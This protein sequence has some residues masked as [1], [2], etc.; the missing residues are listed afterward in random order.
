M[1]PRPRSCAL[2]LT[3]LGRQLLAGDT[4]APEPVASGTAL[5]VQPNFEVL[6][7]DALANLDLLSSLDAF[8]ESHSLDRAAIYRLTRPALVRGLEAG[9][10]EERVVGLLE[11]RSGAPL[12]Q[13]VRQTLHDWAREYERIHLYRDATLLEAPDAATLDGWLA[14]PKLASLLDRRLTA[15]TALLRPSGATAAATGLER[16]GVAVTVF[17]YALDAPQTLD[18]VGPDRVI[19]APEDDDP[20]LRYRLD[21]FADRDDGAAVGDTGPGGAAIPG[22]I[23]YRIGRESLARARVG[24]Q[25][26]DEILSFLGYK[27]RV[28]LSPDD[29]LTLR[30]WSGYYA[31]FRWAKVRA[32]ELPPTVSWGDLSRVKA[33]RPLILRVLS[34]SLALVSEEHWPE[35]EAALLA[36]GIGLKG[37][38]LAQ[39]AAERESAARRVAD[40]LGLA[41][42]RDLLERGAAPAPPAGR[43]RTMAVRHGALRRLAGRPLTEFVEEAIDAERLLAIEY[44]KPGDRRSA[45]RIVE[46]LG[47]EVRGGA[48]YLHAFCL[49]RQEE[50]DF[51]LGNIVGVALAEEEC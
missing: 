4:P 36:R 46:P 1:S 43:T 22:S 51:R 17:N 9:W 18:F 28:G 47:L 10:T 3:G 37:G 15:T 27:A 44:R 11:E 32:V 12:P 38:L 19:I 14:D 48:Y 2:R 25:T 23:G 8:A 34:A 7:L 16:R 6:V 31:P 29:V 40:S 21:R 5:I 26:I 39:P 41:T 50:R 35:L 20:Y 13:N 49:T 30:G 24:G 33:L 42:G 45:I